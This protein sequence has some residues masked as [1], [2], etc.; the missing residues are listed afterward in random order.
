MLIS[1]FS[2]FIRV[3]IVE[4]IAN[5]TTN[6]YIFEPYR[7]WIERL[8]SY[9]SKYTGDKLTYSVNCHLCTSTQISLIINLTYLLDTNLYIYIGLSILMGR[10]SY[11][12]HNL[13][14]VLPKLNTFL[15]IK[16]NK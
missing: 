11:V 8:E 14:E 2:F 7:Q 15:L 12:I 16:M 6:T 10:I 5:L 3:L 9:I 13:Y 1:L 4:A